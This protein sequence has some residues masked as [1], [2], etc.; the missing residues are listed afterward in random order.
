MV[1]IL[2]TLAIPS[3]SA[4]MKSNRIF[5]AA[6]EVAV[7]YRQARVRAMGRGSAVMFRFDRSG[8]SAGSVVMLEALTPLADGATEGACQTPRASCQQTNWT[9]ASQFREI[10]RFAPGANVY[11]GIAMTMERGTGD[12]PTE[13]SAAELCFTPLGRLFYRTNTGSA[14]T[15]LPTAND[16]PLSI[17]VAR[18]DGISFARRV[19]LPTNGASSVEAVTP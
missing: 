2:A 15:P 16:E 17:R 8:G 14:F 9:D 10:A 13:L 6:Q 1:A 19:L 11:E 5:R 3:I 12:E 18:P 4:Q 7:L